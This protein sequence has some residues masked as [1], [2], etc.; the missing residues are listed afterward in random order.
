M[1]VTLVNYPL[2][3]DHFD[4]IAE[5]LPII[6]FLMVVAAIWFGCNNAARDIV[7]EW[8]IYKR[9]RMVTLKLLP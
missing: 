9:E 7:G 6:H 2:R 4:E 3:A 8:T 1:L 5:K